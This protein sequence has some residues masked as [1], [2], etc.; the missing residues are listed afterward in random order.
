MITKQ[1]PNQ[2]ELYRKADTSVLEL[3]QYCEDVISNKINSCKKHK[4]ACM[5][6]L[7]D[8]DKQGTEEFPWVF[9]TD[10]ANRFLRW[11]TYFKHTKGPLAMK[12]KIPEP[13]EKFIFGNVYGWEHK[14]TKVRRFRFLYWQ[15]A[16]KNAKSQDLAMAGLY[17]MAAMGEYTSEVYIAATKKDQTR[18]VWGEARI[19]S[20]NC[21]FL[22]GKILTKAHDDLAQKVIMHPKSNSFFA[23]MTEEDK[24]K[25]DGSNPQCG[26]LDEYHAHPTTEYYDIITSGMKTRKQPLLMIITTA[27]F[28]LNNPCYREEYRYVSQILDPDNETDNDRYFAMVNELELDENGELIDDI[29]DE[30]TW[31]KA[32][33][34]IANTPEGMES[35][36]TELKVAQDKPEKMRDFLTKT[37]NIWLNQRSCG[38]MNMAKWK[39][40]GASEKRPFPDLRGLSPVIGVDLTSKIDFASI[41]FEF[42]LGEL[43]AVLSHSF[44]PEVTFFEK[45]K[46]DK[47]IHYDQWLKD[48]WIT[49]TPG[50]VIKDKYIIDHIENERKKNNWQTK[51]LAYDLYNATEFATVM[52][53]DYGYE[54]I[55]II[56]GIKTLHE[57]TK[58]LRERVYEKTLIHDNNPVLSW[59]MGNAVTAKNPQGNLMLDKGSSYECI[60]P[61]AALMDAHCLI[62]RKPKSSV[63]EKRGMRSLLD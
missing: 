5:R 21:E 14:D 39:A 32:N 15:V 60:D 37:V 34:I 46:K 4:W 20:A 42:D 23:R 11:M 36:R 16:R 63:Y 29:A 7:N 40:C 41:V 31:V 17:E 38:Y 2:E 22:K 47:K 58:N 13:I 54:P 43:I 10:K 52:E 33:P 12:P 53:D 50:E 49:V 6:F 28:D 56:Q 19:I 25:G 51:K 59:A 8:L 44:M 48:G 1:K 27:G 9:N 45:M 35:I 3:T 26:I 62:V 30:S 24:K 61:A 57:P 55:Q 18:Y